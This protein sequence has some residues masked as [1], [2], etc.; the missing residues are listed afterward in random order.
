MDL[1]QFGEEQSH[2]QPLFATL[3]VGSY[4]HEPKLILH[5]G[6]QDPWAGFDHQNL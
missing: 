6:Q 5:L 3:N 2:P 1:V 4:E